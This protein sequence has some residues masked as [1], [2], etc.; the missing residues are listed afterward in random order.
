MR[1]FKILV[2]LTAVA[3]LSAAATAGP[4]PVPGDAVFGRAAD[5][6]GDGDQDV[7][8]V[9]PEDDQFLPGFVQVLINDG[10]DGGGNWLGFTTNAPIQVGAEPRSVAIGLFNAD[11]HP[12]LAVPATFSNEVRI[13]HG[14]G[15]GGF[16][17][18]ST[19]G[20]TFSQPLAV[21]TADMDDD[22][23]LDLVVSNNV[24]GRVD[25]LIG[26]GLGGF[27]EVDNYFTQSF[28]DTIVLV[29]FDD[30]G[31]LDVA[32]VNSGG[33]SVTVAYNEGD[34]TYSGVV[35]VPVG[36]NPL[37][38]DAADYDL[39]GS[40]DVT[41][42]NINHDTVSV[43]LNNGSG[44]V[45]PWGTLAAVA[46]PIAVA[47]GDFDTDGDA[48]L[49]ASVASFQFSGQPGVIL[50]ENLAVSDGGAGFGAPGLVLLGPTVLDLIVTDVNDD[51]VDDIVTANAG[52]GVSTVLGSAE[53]AC[54]LP[55]PTCVED[56]TL[57][58]CETVGG[59]WQGTATACAGVTCPFVDLHLEKTADVS[60]VCDGTPTP[61]TF[62]ITLTNPGGFPMENVT[63]LDFEC[64]P[65]I[66]VGGD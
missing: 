8:I 37:D 40:P 23:I 50:Y 58:E 54:C 22:G 57:L 36:D 31:A 53:G 63:V 27:T 17:L 4:V 7:V 60:E 62:T 52:G 65:V 28:P 3:A 30:D 5:L 26:D 51:G 16:T 10:N 49:V 45:L 24:P 25:T 13:L 64:D 20:T 46:Q 11:A 59:V 6:D 55:G 12:D 18:G 48:D 47:S 35:H 34:G 2:A 61:V 14:D 29:D 56:Q 41:T 15:A 1:G 44:S 38:I 43:L 21:A 32:T 19:L 66:F 42:S 9:R 39:D 33:D